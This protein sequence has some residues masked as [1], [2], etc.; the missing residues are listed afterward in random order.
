M[1][2]YA[3]LRY[4]Y[5]DF[6]SLQ[7]E[8]PQLLSDRKQ[9]FERRK[10][11][12]NSFMMLSNCKFLQHCEL[13][14]DTIT[15]DEWVAAL[16]NLARASDGPAACHEL[17][18]ADHKR[19]SAEKTDAKIAEVLSNMSPRTCEYIQ[20]TL[21]FKHC[22]NCPVKCP[23]GW[24]LANIPRAMA[25][26]RAVTMPN[27][28]TVFTPEVIGAL[29]LL[30]KEAP[31]EFQNIRHGLKDISI[32]MTYPKSLPRNAGKVFTLSP[33]LPE[34]HLRRKEKLNHLKRRNHSFLIVR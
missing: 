26:L 33:H 24:A 17:S 3:D 12:G 34:V 32:L 27:P 23:S 8:I 4:R 16:S 18:K 11:D 7:V 25:T 28:E 20:K 21:G 13:D 6:A 14:A 22:E 30:Q 31:L 5:K 9:G 15:Y 29:A 2:E 10:T 1:I 19:Y